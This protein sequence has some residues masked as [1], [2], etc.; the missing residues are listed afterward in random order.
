[1]DTTQPGTVYLIG[2]GPGD[3]G[4]LTVK[5]LRCLQAADVVVYDYLVDEAIVRQGRADAEYI[6]V[7]KRAGQHTLEQD[8][9]NALLVEHARAGRTVARLKGGDPF[10]FG[11]GGEEAQTLAAAGI[12]WE[13]VPGISSAIAAPAYAGI[14]VTQRGMAT[15]F[16]VI[17]G[18]EDPTKE[19]S[20]IDWPSLG[21]GTGTLVFLMGVG[22]LP[23]IAAQLMAHGRDAA[24]PVAVIRW[25]T[26][27]R[28]EVVSGTLGDIAERA[29]A[30]G[31]KPPAVTV[32]GPVAALRDELAWFD[33]RPLWGRRIIITRAT[34]QAPEL[35]ARLADLGATTQT[36]STIQ[37]VPAATEPLDAEIMAVGSGMYTWV[38]F[39]SVNGVAAYA[40]RLEALGYDW[41]ALNAKVAAIGPATA[42]ALR[43]HG[44]RPD[45]VPTAYVAEAIAE[46]IGD[47]NEERVL[48]P[49]ADI[50]R[51]ALADLL[52]QRGAIV[53][54]VAAYRTIT[55]P[56]DPATV[57][58]SLQDPRPDA[59]TFTSSSTVRGFVAALGPMN[60]AEALAGIV[61]ACIGPVTAQTARELG[62]TPTVVAT[63]YTMDGLATALQAAFIS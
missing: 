23:Q 59:I 18:H 58:K 16:T 25:G 2:A 53:H 11:R 61:V 7:G 43:A 49:R 38:I 9:I 29:Q 1:M 22:T 30:A 57:A 5:G 62:I 37:I 21:R 34:E 40:A 63:D 19:V 13:V 20:E 54:E 28:Q 31:I 32:V 45:F 17:T 51:P 3:P 46:E 12:L 52:R 50:A 42:T 15:S 35:A 56:L 48:L 36:L 14:P 27:P 41:R 4:L 10:V 6:Y 44:I 26:T 24:T 47:M 60:P 55:P 39:T 33:R 8:E